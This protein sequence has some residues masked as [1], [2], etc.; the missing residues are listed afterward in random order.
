LRNRRRQ[1]V[2]CAFVSEPL[3]PRVGRRGKAKLN[4]ASFE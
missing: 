2:M 4:A 1:T 3:R